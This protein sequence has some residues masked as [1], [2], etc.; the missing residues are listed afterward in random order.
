MSLGLKRA[1]DRIKKRIRRRKRLLLASI[2]VIFVIIGITIGEDNA[3]GDVNEVYLDIMNFC[4]TCRDSAYIGLDDHDHLTLYDGN[5]KSGKVVRRLF[6][7]DIES[8]ENSLPPESIDQLMNGIQVND[9][10][11]FNS[12]LSSFSDYAREEERTGFK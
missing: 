5:P 10:Q 12:V 6:Q 1:M 7:L 3:R 8:A 4:P 9:D 2:L 11:E